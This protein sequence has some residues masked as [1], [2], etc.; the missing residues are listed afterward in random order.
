MVSILI[1]YN[2]NQELRNNLDQTAAEIAEF[3]KNEDLIEMFDATYQSYL[4]AK[5]PTMHQYSAKATGHKPKFGI[6]SGASSNQK[7]PFGL[8][9]NELSNKSPITNIEKEKRKSLLENAR[10]SL[11]ANEK[12][13]KL[14]SPNELN[15]VNEISDNSDEELPNTES[16][17]D[18]ENEKPNKIN[19]LLGH[20]Q[21]TIDNDNNVDDI[22]F[23]LKQENSIPTIKK[24]KDDDHKFSSNIVINRGDSGSMYG[25]DI[26]DGSNDE[27]DDLTKIKQEINRTA[28]FNKHVK[29]KQSKKLLL[30][31][32]ALERRE[33]DLP[34]LAEWL[35]KKRPRPPYSYQKRYVHI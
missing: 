16:D 30:T 26:D 5:A 2:A 12:K 35:E 31:V 9:I 19:K 8:D 28:T 21:K 32:K 7:S 33:E 10:L 3:T 4:H 11:T 15:I 25:A 22:L 18:S 17:N 27:N 20:S 6:N 24:G 23:K 14:I 13:T 1:K 29:R 34:H